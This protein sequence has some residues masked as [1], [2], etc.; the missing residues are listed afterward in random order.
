MEQLPLVIRYFEIQ[1]EFVGFVA[2]TDGISGEAIAKTIM[3]TINNLGSDM[4]LCRYG[5]S[6]V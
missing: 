4:S 3:E 6:V 2:C 5:D 1:E